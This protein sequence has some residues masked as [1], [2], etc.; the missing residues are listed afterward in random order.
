[1]GTF[2]DLDQDTERRLLKRI[3]ALEKELLAEG[4]E[5]AAILTTFGKAY[6][7]MI[8]C[9]ASDGATLRMLVHLAQ[10]K[11]KADAYDQYDEM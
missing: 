10:G 2:T 3:W 1:M 9:A 4:V 8:G 11:L 6:G 7:A 5:E